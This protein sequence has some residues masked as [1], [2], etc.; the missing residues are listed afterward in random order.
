MCAGVLAT[1]RDHDISPP[2]NQFSL[3]AVKIYI[4]TGQSGLA[5]DIIKGRIF[6]ISFKVSMVTHVGASSSV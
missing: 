1:M 6:S 3:R 5:V 2:C 4:S